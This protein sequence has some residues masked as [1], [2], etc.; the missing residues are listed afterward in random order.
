MSGARS[1]SSDDTQEDLARAEEFG[2]A[3]APADAGDGQVR[4]R[5]HRR[6]RTLG[7][8]LRRNQKF[9]VARRIVA[10]IVLGAAVIAASVFFARRSDSYEPLP[11]VVPTAPAK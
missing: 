5:R 10:I 1:L 11:I 2:T 8:K 3:I 6:H 4:R 9:T 7:D